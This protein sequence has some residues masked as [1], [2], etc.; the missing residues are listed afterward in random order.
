MNLTRNSIEWH[1]ENLKNISSYLDRINE[2][3]LFITEKY[4]RI[5]NEY[6]NLRVLIIRAKKEKKTSFD[7]TKYGVKKNE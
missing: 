2:E 6:D 3:R 1:E 5:Q 7:A 4:S